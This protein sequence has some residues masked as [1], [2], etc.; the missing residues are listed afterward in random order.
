MILQRYRPLAMPGIGRKDG[1]VGGRSED[2]RVILNQDA[3][4]QDSERAFFLHSA[5]VTEDR[6]V[7]DDVVGLPFAGFA[8]GVDQRRVL[9]INRAGLSVGIGLVVVRIEHLKFVTALQEDATVSAPLAFAHDF[10]R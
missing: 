2:F 6:R 4:L 9:F 3:V 5:V 7:V 1:F 8:T 10:R